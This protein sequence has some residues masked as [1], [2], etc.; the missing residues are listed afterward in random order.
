MTP[1][2]ARRKTV[3]PLLMLFALAL[4]AHAVAQSTLQPQPAAI[5]DFS[6]N[7]TAWIGIGNDLMPPP[8][9]P[10][11]V[12]SD[13]QHPYVSNAA[14]RATGAQPNFRV[15]DLSNPI[16]LP[17]TR[18]ALRKQNEEALSGQVVFTRESRCWPTG[19]PAFLLNPVLPIYFLQTPEEVWIILEPDHRVRRVTLNRA[20][21]AN[22]ASSWYGE[23]VGHY[24][25]DTLVVDTI[26][27]NDKTHVD[28][29]RT[30]HTTQLH[31]VERYRM[32]NGG[33]VLEV[34]IRVEDPGAFTMPWTA[35]RRFNRVMARPLE[36]VACAE[37]N[38]DYF[39]FAVE[40]LPQDDTPDF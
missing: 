39:R 16:L 6:S 1:S 5:P 32:L 17:W 10:G 13:P 28:N 7:N 4:G 26:G 20:H 11:P 22:P 25:G 14:A 40:P 31:V 12:T 21:S 33:R 30:P 23:S 27:F 35:V 24:E 19:V 37:N 18:D 34:S 15:A 36:E 29:Y 8:S 38:G 3:L 2:G 9:G